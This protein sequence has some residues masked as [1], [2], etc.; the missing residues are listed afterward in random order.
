VPRTG[1]NLGQSTFF[2]RPLLIKLYM[3]VACRKVPLIKLKNISSTE[4]V[5]G[6]FVGSSYLSHL[7]A[8]HYQNKPKPSDEIKSKDKLNWKVI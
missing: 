4:I 8:G 3:T 1:G 6:Q 7:E 2:V 5:L